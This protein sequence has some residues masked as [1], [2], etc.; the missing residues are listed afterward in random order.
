M[1]K[2]LIYNHDTSTSLESLYKDLFSFGYG[3]SS[4][5]NNIF[6]FNAN[7][8]ASAATMLHT[9]TDVV[10]FV[11]LTPD[12]GCQLFFNDG[13][14]AVDLDCYLYE[15]VNYQTW[16]QSE[17]SY[18]NESILHKNKYPRMLSVIP[19]ISSMYQLSDTG[20]APYVSYTGG[21]GKSLFTEYGNGL[22]F[23]DYFI[24]TSSHY[25]QN[26]YGITPSTTSGSSD[27]YYRLDIVGAYLSGKL[28]KI[29]DTNTLSW[30]ETRYTAR[31]TANKTE[32]N[33]TKN[34]WD[35][36]CGY[37]QI[38]VSSSIGY[39]GGI[40]DT[41]PFDFNMKSSSFLEIISDTH[42]RIHYTPIPY[43]KAIYFD[44]NIADKF[45]IIKRTN[46][47]LDSYYTLIWSDIHGQDSISASLYQNVLSVPQNDLTQSYIDIYENSTSSLSNYYG[48][49]FET[50]HNYSPRIVLEDTRSFEKDIMVSY[51][52]SLHDYQ[53]VRAFCYGY[54]ADISKKVELVF[55][56]QFFESNSLANR[57]CGMISTGPAPS[58]YWIYNVGPFQNTFQYCTPIGSNT[59][60]NISL[61][62]DNGTL[63]TDCPPGIT[64]G[65]GIDKNLTGYGKGLEFWDT[66]IQEKTSRGY[67]WLYSQGSSKNRFDLLKMITNDSDSSHSSPYI[68]GKLY[69]IKEYLSCSWWET[70]YRARMTCDKGEQNRVS[71]S[72]DLFNGYGKINI[73]N[74]INYTGSIISNPYLF[75]TVNVKLS[76]KNITNN[77]KIFYI[78]ILSDSTSVNLYRNN[79]LYQTFTSSIG[80]IENYT[81]SDSSSIES[82]SIN[83]KFNKVANWLYTSSI[84]ETDALPLSYTYINEGL[85]ARNREL[86]LSQIKSDS[87]NSTPWSSSYT[88]ISKVIREIKEKGV[89]RKEHLYI[90][91]DTI[92]QYKD[93]YTSQSII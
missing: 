18:W 82:M 28:M 22:E 61:Y 69:K 11:S 25:L 71:Q 83:Y 64:A 85:L 4:I 32:F 36:L 76:N 44:K 93:Y 16:K 23:W 86:L 63:I 7:S 92:T 66:P 90:F 6:Y 49:I 8:S 9:D 40:P 43:T 62:T 67:T 53:M 87:I 58:Y 47:T 30:W 81:F 24:D 75:P 12:Q 91:L 38:N 70:R 65:A 56:S 57:A 68:M 10:M 19:Y 55:S 15:P 27:L 46:V 78:D 21:N 45:A 80:F 54:G 88:D 26:T 72:H 84:V 1:D 77:K 59:F 33:R 13:Q 42:H 17:Y 37:G 5:K 51:A 35:S 48:I 39:I 50:E 73:L 74:A 29:R 60:S 89:I 3:G 20:S 31:Q 2:I 79:T 41:D 14:V 52:Y 34:D